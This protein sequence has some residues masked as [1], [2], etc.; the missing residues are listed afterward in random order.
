MIPDLGKFVYCT[1][2]LDP[3]FVQSFALYGLWKTIG[4]LHQGRQGEGKR[5]ELKVDDIVAPHPKFG[6]LVATSYA[7]SPRAVYAP[8]LSELAILW[9]K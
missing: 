7:A 9:Y 6:P 8:L 2:V 5:N 4:K 1:F 3:V